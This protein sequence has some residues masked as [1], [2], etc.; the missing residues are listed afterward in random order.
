MLEL[1]RAV[2]N[3]E[4]PD[5]DGSAHRPAD[6]AGSPLL[7]VAF[8]CS[9][10]PFELH[11]PDEFVRFTAEYWYRA[12]ATVAMR[13]KDVAAHPKD[14]P[15]PIGALAQSR[16]YG[17]PYLYDSPK[18]WRGSSAQSC[19]PDPVCVRWRA[20]ASIPRLVRWRVVHER[21]E[22]ENGRAPDCGNRLLSAD[23]H[24]GTIGWQA[25]E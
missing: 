20:Q 9:L 8:L 21:Q 15:E 24:Q 14:G 7:L 12:V 2:P 25:S 3:F 18:A 13:L 6:L 16:G 10:C 1:G 4:L 17:F 11:M 5:A 19:T 23:G 22:M